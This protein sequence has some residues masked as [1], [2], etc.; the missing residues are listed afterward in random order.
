M[1]PYPNPQHEYFLRCKTISVEKGNKKVAKDSARNSSVN[2]IL[3]LESRA[4]RPVQQSMSKTLPI[5]RSV[6][7]RQELHGTS[8]NAHY[9]L[10]YNGE[11]RTRVDAGTFIR[12]KHIQ[13]FPVTFSQSRHSF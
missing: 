1:G 13:E 5:L 2:L 9:D 12:A 4:T 10:A 6:A 8:L 11:T 7:S 3:R